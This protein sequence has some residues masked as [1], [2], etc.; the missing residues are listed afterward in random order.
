[1]ELVKLK[2]LIIRKEKP[3]YLNKPDN[4]RMIFSPSWRKKKNQKKASKELLRMNAN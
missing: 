1:M 3:K 2:V 4:Q